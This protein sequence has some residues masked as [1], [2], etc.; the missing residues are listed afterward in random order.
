MAKRISGIRGFVAIGM[1]QCVTE[2][3]P[4]IDIPILD[5][6]GTDD[7]ESVISGITPKKH[8]ST[9]NLNYSQLQVSANH[10][11]DNED[12]ALIENE[13]IPNT[14]KQQLIKKIYDINVISS[15]ENSFKILKSLV[16][17]S[18]NDP[19][20]IIEIVKSETRGHDFLSKIEEVLK[21]SQPTIKISPK[22]PS[23]TSISWDTPP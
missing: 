16:L 19:K 10:N 12:E 5:L 20:D 1:T 9:H 3:L 14:I 23:K 6:Y 8:A 17:M 4:K 18:E 11:F 2:F 22:P 15:S 13:G 21:K 7:I